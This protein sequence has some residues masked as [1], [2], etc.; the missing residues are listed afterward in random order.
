MPVGLGVQ[1]V[2]VLAVLRERLRHRLAFGREDP[3]LDPLDAGRPL[4]LGLSLAA[5]RGDAGLRLVVNELQSG[6]GG[7]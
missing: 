2:Y 3:V 5:G 1:C 7:L 6:G 4:L